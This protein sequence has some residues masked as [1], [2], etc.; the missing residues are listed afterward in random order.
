MEDSIRDII[1]KIENA[2][3]IFKAI[4]KKY[5][6]FSKNEKNELLRTFHTTTYDGVSGIRD[7]IDKIVACYQKTKAISTGLMRTMLCG[8]L[9]GLFHHSLTLFGL[10]TMLRRSNG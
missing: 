2:K 9:W 6:K 5:K 10:A 3:E 8:L 1:P 7:H 4:N